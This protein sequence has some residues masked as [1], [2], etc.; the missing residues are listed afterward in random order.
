M[1]TR[2]FGC[3]SVYRSTKRGL[4]SGFGN[5]DTFSGTCANCKSAAERMSGRKTTSKRK[6]KRLIGQSIAGFPKSRKHRKNSGHLSARWQVAKT[7]NAT[8]QIE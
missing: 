4:S 2:S 8:F 6:E 1:E 5:V 3:N 7:G